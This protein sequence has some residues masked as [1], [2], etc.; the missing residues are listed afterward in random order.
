ME[1]CNMQRTTTGLL[2]LAMVAGMNPGWMV[3][4]RAIAADQ[5]NTPPLT[6]TISSNSLGN[7]TG[8][9]VHAKIAKAEPKPEAVPAP[10]QSQKQAEL[11][12]GPKSNAKTSKNDSRTIHKTSNNDSKALTK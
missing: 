6:L 10:K 12:P 5:L 7:N 9:K 4:S 2:A 8:A 3:P 1:R 11:M